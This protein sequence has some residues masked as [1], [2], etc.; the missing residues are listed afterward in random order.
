MRPRGLCGLTLIV[1]LTMAC[2]RRA[3][4]PQAEAPKEKPP[5]V[6]QKPRPIEKRLAMRVH[7]TTW[8]KDKPF[9]IAGDLKER[10]KGLGVEIVGNDVKDADGILQVEYIESEGNSYMF[11][12]KGTNIHFTLSVLGNPGAKV[13]LALDG[14]A[15]TPYSVSG[16]LYEAALQE[17]KKD[18]VYAGAPALIAAALKVSG[19][20]SKAV[21]VA[22]WPRVR[23]FAVP[24]LKKAG[25]QPSTPEE[26]ACW[27]IAQGR[28]TDCPR[29]GKPSVAPL[30][31]LL[32]NIYWAD[33]STQVAKALGAIGD[34]SAAGPLLKRLQESAHA[35]NFPEDQRMVL[36]FISALG[37]VGD[38]FALP[39]L[40][41]LAEGEQKLF[42]APAAKASARIRERM[43]ARSN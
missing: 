42:Q 36:A 19:S 12:G 27:A 8:T 13:L 16:S 14:M 18:S 21:R 3:A 38:S 15:S 25:Y 23:G 35:A 40:D 7:A 43:G 28:F 4:A 10:M 9:D 26:E 31:Q 29:I 33:P 24:M 5:Q 39:D 11:G 37:D 22:I 6:S 1:L 32:E 30:L 17:L 20:A 41:R 34:P 2:E